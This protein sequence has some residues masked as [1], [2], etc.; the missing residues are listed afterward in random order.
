MSKWIRSCAFLREKNGALQRICFT[1]QRGFHS[2]GTQDLLLPWGHLS[3]G[4]Q[5]H[6]STGQV[7]ASRAVSPLGRR[8][9]A[10][11]GKRRVYWTWGWDDHVQRF[12]WRAKQRKEKQPWKM[13][14]VT[15]WAL[16]PPR[17][18]DRCCEPNNMYL[19]LSWVGGMNWFKVSCPWFRRAA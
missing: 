5:V 19:I 8:W 9:Q 14:F 12:C 17:P 7:N 11:P 16:D 10:L 2:I 4:P 18:S 15:P 13:A 1:S 3:D 6:I